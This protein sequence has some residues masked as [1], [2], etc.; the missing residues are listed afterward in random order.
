MIKAQNMGPPGIGIP[1]VFPDKLPKPGE[2]KGKTDFKEMIAKSKPAVK[3]PPGDRT[4][5]IKKS[6]QKNVQ[7]FMDS[8][9][10]EFGI[11]PTRFAGA[12]KEL[13]TEKL[14]KPPLETAPEVIGKLNLNSEDE[15]KA[16]D[17]YMQ[18]LLQSQI[19]PATPQSLDNDSSDGMIALQAGVLAKVIADQKAQQ[20]SIP[21]AQATQGSSASQNASSILEKS[22]NA[23]Q[24]LSF[25]DQVPV[26]SA[27]DADSI[28]ASSQEELKSLEELQQKLEKLNQSIDDLASKN[29]L[30]SMQETLSAQDVS[31][32]QPMVNKMNQQKGMLQYKDQVAD[33]SNSN[34]NMIFEENTGL[35]A[36]KKL[37]EQVAL[38]QEGSI[39]NISSVDTEPIFAKEKFSEV[40]TESSALGKDSVK[41][42][43][44]SLEKDFAN[45]S[46]FQQSS[47]EA[48]IPKEVDLNA[49]SESNLGQFKLKSVEE[50]T[51]RTPSSGKGSKLQPMS[52]R[53][54]KSQEGLEALT[55]SFFDAGK[56]DLKT[57]AAAAA[58]VGAALAKNKDNAAN[59]K[60]IL[61]QAR[62]MVTKG[63]GEVKVK[64]SP[65]GMGDILL[66][67]SVEKG[68]VSMHMSAGTDEVKKVLEGSLGE[69][70]NSLANHHIKLDNVKIDV[71]G[72]AN[73]DNQMQRDFGQQG[74]MGRESSRQ[75][76]QQFRDENL[77]QRQ[78]NLFD[79]Q[80]SSFP[81]NKPRP[82]EPLNR[83][84]ASNKMK[85]Y[86]VKKGS[87]LN[88]VA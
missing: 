51:G 37:A 45:D 40:S 53:A 70:K 62:Y 77:A 13:S 75:F 22:V 11:T 4:P 17:M 88:I 14:Q 66:K 3:S 76:L 32:I 33:G 21:G 84:D 59:M 1:Q 19:Q 43:E 44:Q 54:A 18:F 5:D 85:S 10:G 50:E 80:G 15:E 71:G 8:F 61:D 24:N 46:G 42:F 16:L 79:M 9:E 30:V 31:E 72:A 82:I 36:N 41:S 39:E 20:Q 74:D 67:V 6:P 86:G 27:V 35:E 23:N 65:E 48:L 68:K 7:E 38:G 29:N 26:Q 25:L 34:P 28:A 2:L 47:Q 69:L 56:G 63:G 83:T 55:N 81:R 64:M 52:A 73:A 78:N 57:E 87:G 58:G 49:N 12:M 60:N